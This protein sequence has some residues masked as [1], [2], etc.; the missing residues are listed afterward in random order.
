MNEDYLDKWEERAKINYDSTRNRK[1][2]NMREAMSKEKNIWKD[3][4]KAFVYGFLLASIMYFIA[5]CM[6][7]GVY[8]T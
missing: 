6:I 5:G 3:N 8:F 2:A 4:H 1:I 7:I